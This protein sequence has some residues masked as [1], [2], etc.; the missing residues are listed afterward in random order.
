[1]C[2]NY[3]TMFLVIPLTF[4]VPVGELLNP[5]N[6]NNFHTIKR[7]GS[8]QIV[9]VSITTKSHRS[10]TFTSVFACCSTTRQSLLSRLAMSL[11]NAAVPAA[12]HGARSVRANI[13]RLSHAAQRQR[14]RRQVDDESTKLLDERS[15]SSDV[16]RGTVAFS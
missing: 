8:C 3:N 1:M 4:S 7:F 11:A 16:E 13:T 6:N 5:Y 12:L 10:N 9:I 15:S 2:A 14:P